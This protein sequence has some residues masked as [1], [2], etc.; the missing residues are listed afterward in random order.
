M[1]VRKRAAGTAA[2]PELDTP[3]TVKKRK[4]N[5]VSDPVAFNWRFLLPADIVVPSLHTSS[6]VTIE[7]CYQDPCRGI[8][9]RIAEAK[10]QIAREIT[11]NES[12]L[13]NM[14][15]FKRDRCENGANPLGECRIPISRM[16]KRHR[17][18]PRLESSSS[19]N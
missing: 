1:S 16:K 8:V 15:P 19:N 18:P 12:G 7:K 2:S 14:F 9:R 6:P 17:P 13:Q 10:I 11:N 3:D 5:D 4:K